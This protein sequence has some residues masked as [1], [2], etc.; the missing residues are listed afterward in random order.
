M[1]A[2]GTLKMSNPNEPIEILVTELDHLCFNHGF[3]EG[4]IYGTYVRLCISIHALQSLF[5]YACQE[6]VFVVD[7]D[8][9]YKKGGQIRRYKR[10]KD[11][12]NAA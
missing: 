4:E 6:G 1:G 10:A 7:N 3:I 11:K 9:F 12:A 8:V 2:K 5:E